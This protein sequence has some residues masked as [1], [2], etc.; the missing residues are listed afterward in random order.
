MSVAATSARHSR[1]PWRI[2]LNSSAPTETT[3]PTVALRDEMTPLSGASTRACASRSCCTFSIARCAC[4]RACA[5][6]S[7][8]NSWLM[9]CADSTPVGCRS[10]ARWALA[11]ASAKVAS[12]SATRASDCA[13]SACGRSVAKVASS[14]PRR[15]TSPTLT[16]TSASRQP[17]PSAPTTAS[18]QAWMVPPA[19][20]DC[21]MLPR[22]GWVRV[23][24]NE[25][26]VAG[27]AAVAAGL[28]AA[29]AAHASTHKAAATPALR[30]KRR[31]PTPARKRRVM[32]RLRLRC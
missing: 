14:W 20:T 12:A 1:R 29:L 28:S 21:A 30:Q 32:R 24:L 18:C 25:G 4:S 7:R 9:A 17:L 11:A 13:S 23:T 19:G 3:A 2:S 15:T 16:W 31:R 5:V 6:R 27:A 10:R 26:R 8:V 22:C